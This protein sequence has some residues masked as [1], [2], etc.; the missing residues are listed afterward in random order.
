M[1]SEQRAPWNHRGISTGDGLVG[2][3]TDRSA[4]DSNYFEKQW[5]LPEKEITSSVS[6][7]QRE[8]VWRTREFAYSWKLFL[9]KETHTCAPTSIGGYAPNACYSIFAMASVTL[10]PNQLTSV[11]LW[12]TA[13]LGLPPDSRNRTRVTQSCTSY[14][15]WTKDRLESKTAIQARKTLR[16]SIHMIWS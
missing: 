15:G 12:R 2:P 6:T 3:I 9:T 14:E 11:Y 8:I 5:N 10:K 1:D 4:P 16:K 7:N 13:I